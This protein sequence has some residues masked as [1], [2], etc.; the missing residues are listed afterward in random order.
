MVD[1]P[2]LDIFK[3]E[4]EPDR[5]GKDGGDG[6]QDPEE[7]K[8]DSGGKPKKKKGGAFDRLAGFFVKALQSG[9]ADLD[10]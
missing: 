5:D 3:A 1:T 8:E 7:E 6:N 4:T 2:G 10:W 9:G